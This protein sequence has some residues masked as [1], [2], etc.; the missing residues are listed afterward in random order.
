MASLFECPAQPCGRTR[1]PHV[2]PPGGPTAPTHTLR[3]NPY[4]EVT[5]R[6]CRLP[7]LAFSY[8]L[9]AVHLGDLM[10][11]WVR[12]RASEKRR[13]VWCFTGGGV[14]VGHGDREWI[15]GVWVWVELLRVTRFRSARVRWV[16]RHRLTWGTPSLT[17]CAT[18]H[19]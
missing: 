9:E 13:R 6:I 11:L 2:S 1:P 4:P 19:P 10:R 12:R 7:L 14:D 15:S 3:A 8:R 17:S 18:D 5:D 16:L